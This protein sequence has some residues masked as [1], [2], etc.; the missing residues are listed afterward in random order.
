MS[1]RIIALNVIALHRIDAEGEQ[2][3]LWE[4]QW[5][6]YG[7]SGPLKAPPSPVFHRMETKKPAVTFL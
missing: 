5:E 1:F 2:T 6:V 7:K 3:F 4:V